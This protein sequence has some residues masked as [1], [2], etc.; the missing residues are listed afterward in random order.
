MLDGVTEMRFRSASLPDSW[1]GRWQNCP[2]DTDST[3]GGATAKAGLPSLGQ[4]RYPWCWTRRS[5]L[6]SPSPPLISTV[7]VGSVPGAA[8]RPGGALQSSVG[9]Q[10]KTRTGAGLQFGIVGQRDGGAGGLAAC[11]PGCASRGPMYH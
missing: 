6:D 2:P 1:H 8:R 11:S 7:T 3:E 5:R 4:H 9:G 10:S